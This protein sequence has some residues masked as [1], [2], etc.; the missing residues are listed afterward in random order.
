MTRGRW[1][2]VTVLLDTHVLLWWQAGGGRL[3]ERADRVIREAE[4]LLVSPL[5]CW[6]ITTLHRQ[7]R[8]ELDR[9]PLRWVQA[10]F[11]VPR[12]E[13]AALTAAAA[14]WA[15]TLDAERFPGDP[16]DRMLYATALDLRVPFL[17]RDE[18]LRDYARRA[19]D[20]DVR[21]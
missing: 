3:S 4:R 6:E 19:G 17:T 7:G 18:R 14:A 1:S 12:V 16:I 11:H 21:W 8:I 9:D 10:L 2:G 13:P 15:G 5:S 20:V